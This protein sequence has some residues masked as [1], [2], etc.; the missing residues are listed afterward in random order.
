M[1]PHLLVFGPAVE[2]HDLAARVLFAAASRVT[3]HTLESET[4]RALSDAQ[5][6]AYHARYQN[7]LL[8]YVRSLAA[9]MINVRREQDVPAAFRALKDDDGHTPRDAWGTEL[10]I[11]P[12]AWSARNNRWYAVR[13]AGPDR[14]FN[15]SDDLAVWVESEGFSVFPDAPRTVIP[16]QMVRRSC[17]GRHWR[18]SKQS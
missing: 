18:L 8:E 9:K 6:A 11:E 5:S 13:S 15:M 7:A 10:V 2:Q 4:G 1:G 14:E 12:A 3:P 17:G 16:N